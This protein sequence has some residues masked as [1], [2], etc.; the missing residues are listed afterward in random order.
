MVNRA[1]P[2]KGVSSHLPSPSSIGGSSESSL[3]G[4]DSRSAS[5][6]GAGGA[7]DAR[8]DSRKTH[9]ITRLEDGTVC[10]GADCAVIRI[11][12]TG[13]IQIDARNC[14]DD[15]GQKLTE[16]LMDGAGADF[17]LNPRRK[18]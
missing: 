10:I 16:R 15:V 18:A 7:S 13:D 8:D 6:A 14:P 17:K 2:R 12:P 5:R 9:S 11:P 1:R 4:A 3:A